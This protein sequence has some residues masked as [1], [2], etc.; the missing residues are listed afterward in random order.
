MLERIKIAAK[1]VKEEGRAVPT[2][3]VYSMYTGELGANKTDLTLKLKRV[4]VQPTHHWAWGN[5]LTNTT[6]NIHV[7]E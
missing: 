1:G 5:T 2:A 4:Y 3:A 6:S 7:R